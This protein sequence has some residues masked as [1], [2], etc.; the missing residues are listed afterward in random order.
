VLAAMTMPERQRVLFLA[1]DN[2]YWR[3]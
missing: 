1:L 2:G 3:D